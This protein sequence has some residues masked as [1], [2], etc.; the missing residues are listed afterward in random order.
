MNGTEPHLAVDP[1]AALRGSESPLREALHVALKHPFG[2]GERF[3]QRLFE[4]APGA[5]ELFPADLVGQQQKFTRTLLTVIDALGRTETAEMAQQLRQLGARHRHYGANAV[6]YALVGQALGEALG[7]A[8]PDHFASDVA[9]DWQRCY[10]WIA[11]AMLSGQ[12]AEAPHPQ[13]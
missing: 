13:P 6:H 12:A 9:A 11:L 10:A 8:A 5:R 3:Y 7:A 1:L 2:F 4:L